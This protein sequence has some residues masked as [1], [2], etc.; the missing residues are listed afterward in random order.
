V[1]D[2]VR[3]KNWDDWLK[4]CSDAR[5]DPYL[6]DLTKSIQQQLLI[7][8]AAR[9][10]QGYY[11]KG[12]T[13]QAQTPKTALRH[14]AQTLVLAGYPDP[15]QSY[16]AHELDLPFSKLLRSYKLDDPAPKPQ[17]ALPVR[18]IQCAVN[19]YNDKQTLLTRAIANLLTTAFFFLLHP[20][21]Y[22]MSTSCA[23]KRT[24]QF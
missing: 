6:I 23:K 3:A 2:Q 19:F 13:V 4:F 7:A 18:A 20:G 14:V 10:R 21:K 24:I 16:S 22:T 9:V 15:C 8:F 17:L 11:G 12:N 1:D 5:H